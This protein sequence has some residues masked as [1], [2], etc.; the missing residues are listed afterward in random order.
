MTKLKTADVDTQPEENADML[1]ISTANCFYSLCK[2][3][4]HCSGYESFYNISTP[5][6][7][8]HNIFFLKA[9]IGNMEK[10]YTQSNSNIQNI[11][12]PWYNTC[13]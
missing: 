7:Q 9:S 11:N 4:C 2:C 6:K 5:S 10:L 8:F 1:I 13:F 12:T 3:S